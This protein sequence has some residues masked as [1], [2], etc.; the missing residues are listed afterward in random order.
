M[1]CRHADRL[2]RCRA[3]A[4]RPFWAPDQVFSLS[5][6]CV[7]LTAGAPQRLRSAL[8]QGSGRAAP[9]AAAPTRALAVAAPLPVF[10]APLQRAPERQN[11]C[12]WGS[13][14]YRVALPLVG[15]AQKKA[16]WPKV[17]FLA[18]WG[19]LAGGGFGRPELS[20][21]PGALGGCFGRPCTRGRVL[22]TPPRADV[23][24][25]KRPFAP[26]SARFGRFCR[27]T[28]HE[29]PLLRS[30]ACPKRAFS[31]HTRRALMLCARNHRFGAL[32]RPF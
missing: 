17:P 6:S 2:A 10:C 31:G 18:V 9:R 20:K 4:R 13:L 7:V 26:K 28:R 25:A 12:F 32:K 11:R 5:L 23:L 14:F 16:L 1:R 8:R 19:G 3:S 29:S 21:S 22:G 24:R 27:Y 15:S 30:R